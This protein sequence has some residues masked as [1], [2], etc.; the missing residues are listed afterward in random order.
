MDF[1]TVKPENL[2]P[3]YCT[4]EDTAA[5][6]CDRILHLTDK[7]Y[8]DFEPTH[9]A[10]VETLGRIADPSSLT[11]KQERILAFLEQEYDL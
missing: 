11:L 9:A 10:V 6:N 8:E 5:Q 3:V 7:I 2:E 1:P 4:S